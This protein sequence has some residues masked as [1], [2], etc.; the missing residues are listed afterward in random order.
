MLSMRIVLVLML[1]LTLSPHCTAAPYTPTECCFRYIKHTL[2][3]ANLKDCY[4]TPKECFFPAV[5]FETKNGNK[6]CADPNLPWVV[7]AAE[8]LQKQKSA[9]AP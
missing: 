6:L 7:K 9:C 8:K 5:V 1:L 4:E 3:S 2:R